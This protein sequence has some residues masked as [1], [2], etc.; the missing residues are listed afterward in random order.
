M[1]GLDKWQIRVY[2]QLA[3]AWPR[4]IFGT[5]TPWAAPL[6][7][8][9][10]CWT[11]A[12]TPTSVTPGT[13]TSTTRIR[14][15]QG[16][17]LTGPCAG[18]NSLALDSNGNPHI[19][20]YNHYGYIAVKYAI[21]NETESKWELYMVDDVGYVGEWNSLALDSSDD[22]H[23]SYRDGTNNDLYA[24]NVPEP[25]TLLLFGLGLPALIAGRRRKHS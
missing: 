5:L 20:Y 14:T 8:P 23:I 25:T 21:W 22:P 19:S 17:T 15:V 18:Y 6:G 2:Y 9:P 24:Y 13:T 4:R 11:T 16:G 10:W 7:T 12:A 1:T 3:G